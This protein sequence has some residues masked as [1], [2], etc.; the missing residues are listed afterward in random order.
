MVHG[1]VQLLWLRDLLDHDSRDGFVPSVRVKTARESW[2]IS[3]HQSDAY[4]P[5]TNPLTVSPDLAV[6]VNV[7]VFSTM[8]FPN[9]INPLDGI[10]FRTL[11]TIESEIP[12]FTAS[13][14]KAY[15]KIAV[16]LN[17]QGGLLAFF[18]ED[19]ILQKIEIILQ[20]F[21]NIFITEEKW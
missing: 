7:G 11:H 19:T 4:G 14:A 18:N 20:E 10:W 5:P 3:N 12:T 2:T 6:L 13:F 1:V 16:E 17:L 15:S 21:K 9:G 8:I